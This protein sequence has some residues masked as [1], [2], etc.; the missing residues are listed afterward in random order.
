MMKKPEIFFHFEVIKLLV[1]AEMRTLG[2]KSILHQRNECARKTDLL[3]FE[4]CPNAQM[5]KITKTNKR[6][7]FNGA[8]L[9]IKLDLPS[10]LQ[11]FK[12]IKLI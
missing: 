5:K 7:S 11:L 2:G 10:Y 6:L 4:I 8:K 3:V 9:K 1:S 12:F